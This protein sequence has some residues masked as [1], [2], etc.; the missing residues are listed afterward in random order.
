[1]QLIGQIGGAKAATL[2]HGAGVHLIARRTGCSG[3]PVRRSTIVAALTSPIAG[4]H[5]AI[6]RKARACRFPP[7]PP[8][9]D[10]KQPVTHR[11]ANAMVSDLR[12]SLIPKNL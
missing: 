9:A 3:A 2:G 6:Q 4:V 11:D 7:C 5:S 1:M 10:A 8:G 12:K